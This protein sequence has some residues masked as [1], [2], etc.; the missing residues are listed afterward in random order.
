MAHCTP[1]NWTKPAGRVEVIR[2]PIGGAVSACKRQ[3]WTPR[4]NRE[5]EA[6]NLSLP[7]TATV[8]HRG[9]LRVVTNA[10]IP[11]MAEVITV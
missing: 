6:G 11:G 1:S 5:V 8:D 9:K 2:T 4:W 7:M 3:R 10:L